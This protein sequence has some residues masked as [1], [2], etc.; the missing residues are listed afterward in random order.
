MQKEGWVIL[1]F[2][3]SIR[4]HYSTLPSV[5]PAVARPA[6]RG[7]KPIAAEPHHIGQIRWGL[8]RRNFLKGMAALLSAAALPVAYSRQPEPNHSHPKIYVKTSTCKHNWGKGISDMKISPEYQ[9]QV[10]HFQ[11]QIMADEGITELESVSKSYA[12]AFERRAYFNYL[13][14]V[15]RHAENASDYKAMQHA[16]IAFVDGLPLLAKIM[17]GEGF[18]TQRQQK[19]A[20]RNYFDRCNE[21]YQ[22]LKQNSGRFKMDSQF[23]YMG[24]TDLDKHSYYPG[25]Q[26]TTLDP[27]TMF[28]IAAKIGG[29]MLQNRMDL[30]RKHSQRATGWFSP[31]MPLQFYVNT[32]YVPEGKHPFGGSYFTDRHCITLTGRNLWNGGFGYPTNNY[33]IITHEFGHTLLGNMAAYPDDMNRQDAQIFLAERD[34]IYNNINLNPKGCVPDQWRE[35]AFE[36]EHPSHFFIVTMCEMF[37]ENP[38][39]IYDVSS[40]KTN[41][42]KDGLYEVY[43]RYLKLDPLNKMQELSVTA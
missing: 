1:V 9:Q 23:D 6:Y 21:I 7:A 43:C 12:S 10:A 8:S 3:V 18:S 30:W 42:G 33:D 32:N 2:N 31:K 37:M 19:L 11:S 5:Q 15:A 17:S 38:Q 27:S 20:L 25:R 14:Q 29:E 22:H 35:Y 13:F 41:D 34:R 16:S 36:K 4:Q 40:R 24:K 39:S 28:I 26:T